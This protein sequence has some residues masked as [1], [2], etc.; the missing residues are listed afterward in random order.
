MC[1]ITQEYRMTK[2][3]AASLTTQPLN[4]NGMYG[5]CLCCS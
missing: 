2:K 1:D 5:M 4:Q 3:G